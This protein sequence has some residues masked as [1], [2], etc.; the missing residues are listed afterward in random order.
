MMLLVHSLCLF[1]SLAASG[2][3]LSFGA[4]HGPGPQ[5]PSMGPGGPGGPQD[6]KSTQQ[7]KVSI[8][9]TIEQQPN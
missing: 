3:G 6:S 9:I 5:N 2:V 7:K 1:L 8:G 4:G